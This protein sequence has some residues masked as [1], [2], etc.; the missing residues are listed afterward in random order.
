MCVCVCVWVCVC[1]CVRACV[2]VRARVFFPTVSIGDNE[3]NYF[4]YDVGTET[5]SEDDL[6]L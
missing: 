5:M 6:R 2:S 3:L 1:V 4:A